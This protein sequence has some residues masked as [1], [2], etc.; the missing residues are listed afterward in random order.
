MKERKGEG[1]EEKKK[2]RKLAFNEHLLCA[3]YFIYMSSHN[4]YVVRITNLLDR[5]ET[6]AQRRPGPASG[7]SA[8]MCSRLIGGTRKIAVQ[9]IS[10][11]EHG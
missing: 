1:R 8:S 5:V 11:W 9:G 7:Y 4:P 2:E 10:K 3:G 6:A